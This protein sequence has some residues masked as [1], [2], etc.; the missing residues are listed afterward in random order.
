MVRNSAMVIIE[1]AYKKPPSLFRMAPSLTPY[2]PFAQ[3]GSPKCTAPDQLLDACC[4]LANMIEDVN[5]IFLHTSV[6]AF[7]QITLA[8][9]LK[10]T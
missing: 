9:V 2:Y 3:N 4:Y 5:E 1:R 6:V 8:L 7:C 10:T